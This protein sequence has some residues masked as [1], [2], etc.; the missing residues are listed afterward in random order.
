MSLSNTRGV[1][2]IHGSYVAELRGVNGNLERLNEKLKSL[3]N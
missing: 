1:R 3:G 2:M